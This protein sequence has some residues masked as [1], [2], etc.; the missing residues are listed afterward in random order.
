MVEQTHSGISDATGL[1]DLLRLSLAEDIGPGDITTDSIIDPHVV[2]EGVIVSHEAGVMA[3]GPIVDMVFGLLGSETSW[4]WFVKDGQPFDKDAVIGRVRTRATVILTGERLALNIL[5]RLCGIAFLTHQFVSRLSGTGVFLL[6][7]RK[8]S[9]GLRILERYAVRMG[10]GVNHRFGLFDRILI[11]ENH[12]VFIA[13]PSEAIHR[14]R[15][16]NPDTVIEIEVS[17]EEDFRS[18]LSANPDWILLDNMT[19][20]RM[21]RCVEIRNNTKE[22]TVRLEA[23]GG[24]GLNTVADIA[25]T[26]IDAIS[27][28]ALTHSAVWLDLS[29]DVTHG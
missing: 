16:K 20:E 24:V 8:T 9:P 5:Q 22:C 23:S 17:G 7:T 4:S 10:G 28:G 11:K 14:A 12:L 2:A 27:A 29:M 13:D 6:D 25:R 26:G 1:R 3:G 21:K 15:V 19:I 18:A